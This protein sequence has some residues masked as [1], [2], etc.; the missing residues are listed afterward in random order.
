M[1]LR[2]LR[3]SETRITLPPIRGSEDEAARPWT[4][5]GGAAVL[6]ARPLPSAPR[7]PFRGLASQALPPG[8]WLTLDT[9]RCT[10]ALWSRP[11]SSYAYFQCPDLSVT[12][13]SSESLRGSP[14]LSSRRARPWPATSP[15]ASRLSRRRRGRGPCGCALAP[16]QRSRHPKEGVQRQ[17]R[18][19]SKVTPDPE[20]LAFSFVRYVTFGNYS[21]S[22]F[23]VSK[24]EIG[25]SISL[26]IS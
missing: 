1:A 6:P 21:I 2:A 23:P 15:S 14:A 22:L 25:M 13:T 19:P 8:P 4:P 18:D 9:P 11:L 10:S 7:P 16:S 5:R 24:N 17:H 3:S 26:Q 12:V 20:A